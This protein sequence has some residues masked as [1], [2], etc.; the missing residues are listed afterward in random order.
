MENHPLVVPLA[1]AGIMIVVWATVIG[2]TR[3]GMVGAKKWT[4]KDIKPGEPH[5]PAWYSALNRVLI[6][7]TESFALF[8]PAAVLH[9]VMKS[10]HSWLVTLAWVYVAARLLYALVYI[11][12]GY[13][14]IVSIVW[15]TAFLAPLGHWVALLLM[16]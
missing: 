12:G 4:Y 16:R 11:F 1:V 10:P 2:L 7:S 9:I 15:L 13:S 8:A 3:F 14:I 6:N 5:G